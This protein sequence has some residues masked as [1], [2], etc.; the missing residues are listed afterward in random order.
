M[1][2]GFKRARFTGR[3][4][5]PL[6]RLHRDQSLEPAVTGWLAVLHVAS[7]DQGVPRPRLMSVEVPVQF[8]N[9]LEMG[10]FSGHKEGIYADEEPAC[11]K[12]FVERTID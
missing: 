7:R 11:V 3:T 5:H 1:P 2:L 6:H 10:Y 9:M 12:P 4:V 8:Q